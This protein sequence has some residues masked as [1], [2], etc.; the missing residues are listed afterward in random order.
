MSSKAVSFEQ[1]ESRLLMS[2]EYFIAPNGSDS[3]PGTISLPFATLEGAQ[4]AIRNLKSTTG[5]PDGGVV[6]NLREGVYRRTK[7]F[8]LTSLDSGT[9]AKPIVYQA[10]NDESVR[11]VG[12]ELVDPS[13][14]TLVNSS[15]PVWD[16]LTTAAKGNLYELDLKAHGITNYGTFSPRAGWTWNANAA[17]ELFYDG[18]V[19]QLGR[20]PNEGSYMQTGTVTATAQFKYT[21]QRVERWTTAEDPQFAGLFATYW[22]YSTVGGTINTTAD[23]ITLDS[24][25]PYSVKA[26]HPIFAFNLLEEIDIPG[27]WYLN[28]T[29]CKLYFW[30]PGGA[31]TGE[32]YLS[33]L[34]DEL[35]HL[36]GASYITF[37]GMTFEMTRDSL[38]QIDNGSNNRITNSVLRNAGR[39]GITISGTNN[40]ID[41]SH[42]Y[43]IGETAVTLTGG[44]RATLTEAGNY[45]KNSDIHD[46]SR[47]IRASKVAIRPEGVG[48]IIAHNEIHDGPAM[49]IWYVG[50]E[51][52][53]E[54][55]EIYNVCT[56][57]QDAGAIYMG[58][59]WGLRG[60]VI[61]YNYIHDVKSRF[62]SS[63]LFA[64]YFDD[65][66]SQAD[67]YG[68]IFARIGGYAGF[69]AGGRDNHWYNNLIIDSYG[70]HLGDR[71][72]M[73]IT[74]DIPGDDCNFLEKLNRAAGGDFHTG[75]WAAAYPELAKIPNDF[76][77]LGSLKNPGGT[78]F[79]GNWGWNNTVWMKEGSWGG[80]TGAFSYYASTA[81]NVANQDPLFVDKAGG[82]LN[83]RPDSPIYTLI[84]GW[85]DIPFDQIGIIGDGTTTPPPPP[86]PPPAQD[87]SGKVIIDNGSAGFVTTGT[88]NA[89][90]AIDAFGA[91]SITAMQIGAT[92]TW[93][94]TLAA[95]GAQ[96]VF[97]WY[98]AKKSDGTTF[99]R[100]S[101]A[102]YTVYYNGGSKTVT[103]NQD[104]NSGQWVYLGTFE[105]AAGT[106]G[107]VQLLR[108]SN[109]GVST[110]ADAVMFAPVTATV[111]D[112][113]STGFSKTGTWNPSAA[114]D[115][116]DGSS[117]TAMNIG[118]TATWRPTLPLDGSYTVYGWW[119]D[120]KAD[121]TSF[122]RD[123][124]ADYTINFDGGS[125][126]VVVDQDKDSGQWVALGT[127]DFKAG[128][129]GYV[130]LLRDSANGTSTV[131]DAVRFVWNAPVGQDP[132]AVNRD[133]VAADD[134]AAG[135]EDQPLAIANP[136]ANDSDLD[137][138]AL[139]I[140]SFTQGSH[141]S[142]TLGDNGAFTYTPTANY[143]G[144][145]SFTYTVSDGQGGAATATVNVTIASVND[146]PTAQDIAAATDE[147]T[148]LVI[149]GLLGNAAD[150]DGDLLTIAGLS[151]PTHGS[152]VLNN[153]GSVTY[154]P[155]A[156]YFGPDSFSYT[157]TDGKGGTATA[158][159][160]VTVDEV[161]DAPIAQEDVLA[162][163]QGKWLQT[164]DL[165]ANDLNIEGLPLNVVRFTQPT[166]GFVKYNGDGTFSYVSSTNYNGTDSFT[167]TIADPHGCVSTATVTLTVSPSVQTPPPVQTDEVTVDNKSAGFTTT[168]TWKESAAIDEYNGS[169]VHSNIVGST[170]RWTPT[171]PSGGKYDVYVWYSAV[172]SKYSMFD[173]DSAADYTVRHTNGTST[174]TLDQ[175]KTSGQW[176]L[177][178][179]YDFASGTAG[180]VQL[181]RDS[182][183]GVATS[184]DAVKFVRVPTEVV[185]DNAGAGFA[186]TG[187][188]SP[189][190]ATDAFAGSS[191]ASSSVGSTARWTPTL[192]TAGQY[193]VYAWYAAAAGD[194]TTYD[195][196]SAA[197]YV[198]TYSGG[199][200][201][202][203]VDQ[204]LSSGQWVYLGTYAFDAGSSGNVEL[205]MDALNGAAISADAVK[206]VKA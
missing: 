86:P 137:G 107:Y 168:G 45:V 173:R 191:L 113:N 5:L 32:T 76:D 199:S 64:I 117:I 38:I 61:R 28:R 118:S 74:T 158:T 109:D 1:F 85:Q 59:D 119:S 29:T 110:V 152:V 19:M 126:T 186:A 7:S 166:H 20:Y 193:Q 35:L 142:V 147:D 116:Y 56:D 148:P 97:A 82:N 144:A 80:Y 160:R 165:R 92:A 169:S 88:W 12:A 206:L 91:T 130:S 192:A 63:N 167:Y 25:P 125:Q 39:Y 123:S 162:A 185:V 133:P 143:Y 70:G 27:E 18:A 187:A 37:S 81:G 104:S 205:Q 3:N 150:L 103:V 72:G 134:K 54:Y 33:M 176:V 200:T 71:R 108:D 161:C 42:I 170:A 62:S 115:S 203:Y 120:K 22:F 136:L 180:Y 112:D 36:N 171:L 14:F 13:W 178:G 155:A 184:A 58:R 204:D 194:G 44:N 24:N 48:Q 49:A 164:G 46:W 195:R 151:Q 121:G 159:V 50:N 83:L 78:T 146:V 202:V 179:T 90:S 138:D 94:P 100:D 181:V 177:L 149:A 141:G 95:A 131:A 127:F 15:N 57:T 128:T 106:S 68:N 114:V 196:D 65:A 8:D 129:T 174:V 79:T 89:S 172:K 101:S 6:V 96:A 182:N 40:G 10:Y 9:A 26:A 87:T 124:A 21:D 140:A 99:D 53:I 139:T 189:S 145:D 4:T 102:D 157:V 67:V 34:S 77:L 201:T 66:S 190:Y 51:H 132:P 17:L 11:L 23:T 105:F 73:D 30:A 31:P 156:D 198:I 175:D 197:D 84:P 2:A 188:W 60:T 122:D 98:S 16:R 135:L 55:N 41:N 47:W 154:T 69:N 43:D 163:V 75:A 111:V 183:N 93:R 52:L 153:D